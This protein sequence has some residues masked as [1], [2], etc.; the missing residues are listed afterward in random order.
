MKRLGAWIAVGL[1]GVGATP[2]SVRAEPSADERVLAETLFSAGRA[3]MQEGRIPEACRKFEASQSVAPALGTL[4]NLALCHEKEGRLA[5]AWVEFKQAFALALEKRDSDR[6]AFAREH[7]RQLEPQLPML[8]VTPQRHADCLRIHR[9]NVEIP[10]ASWTTKLP[11]DPGVHRLRASCGDRV[12]WEK[13]VTLEPRQLAVVVVPVQDR[14]SSAAPTSHEPDPRASAP[15]DLMQSPDRDDVVG[16]LRTSAWVA[17]ALG[18]GLTC[19]GGYYGIQALRKQ[20]ESE[21]HC[22]SGGACSPAG[23]A[24]S[25]DAWSA[26]H[27]ANVAIGGGLVLVGLSAFTLV[28]THDRA[29]PARPTPTASP[30]VAVRAAPDMATFHMG[31]RY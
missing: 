18:A 30:E 23:A 24:A 10:E 4:L 2:A 22:P 5:T 1:L 9:G 15:V 28:W 13:D 20:D 14:S 17:G 26:S 21:D 12:L 16:P 27:R 8:S 11:V 29:A 25:N 3:L 6:E 31:W 19:L 7:I